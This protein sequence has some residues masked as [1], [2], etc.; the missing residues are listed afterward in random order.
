MRLQILH[1][2]FVGTGQNLKLVLE[3]QNHQTYLPNHSLG[4]HSMSFLR[5]WVPLLSLVHPKLLLLPKFRPE[6]LP[7]PY[8]E[9]QYFLFP[10]NLLQKKQH[11]Q[12]RLSFHLQRILG[13]HQP[14]PLAMLA[15]W[16]APQVLY[17]GQS[18]NQA[19]QSRC[20]HQHSTW[21]TATS[22]A[23]ISAPGR[24]LLPG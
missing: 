6:N 12:N 23:L 2:E 18:A 5:C 16:A 14:L 9:L 15:A 19:L 11:Q 8:L 17:L 21:K 20:Q 1:L 24:L 13:F 22:T 7:S 3:Y 10:E 4:C